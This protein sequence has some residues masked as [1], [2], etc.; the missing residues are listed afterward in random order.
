MMLR[1]VVI[2]LVALSA[3]VPA[4]S[5]FPPDAGTITGI[6]LDDQ[7]KPLAGVRVSTLRNHII[8]SLG[9]GRGSLSAPV[10]TARANTDAQGRYR[11][12]GLRPSHYQLR[13]ER[14]GHATRY[15]LHHRVHAGETVEVPRMRY[16]RGTVVRGTVTL[17][18]HPVPGARVHVRACSFPNLVRFVMGE[19]VTTDA[20]GAFALPVRL[21][22]GHFRFEATRLHRNPLRQIPEMQGSA[23]VIDLRDGVV[24]VALELAP[25]G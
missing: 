17:R 6:V 15:W 14:S 22:P 24:E 25:N 9:F 3:G 11:L 18:G 23:R 5:I 20:H 8:G 10:T 4:R 16:H 19:S 13:L 21:P 2:G 7:G 12:V 1:V